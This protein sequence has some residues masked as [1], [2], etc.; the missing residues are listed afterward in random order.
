MELVLELGPELL[1]EQLPELLQG[2][3]R[4]QVQERGPGLVQGQE[5][6]REQE[7]PLVGQLELLLLYLQLL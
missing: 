6:Y 1:L 7:H 2:R 4:E 3:Q 5:V